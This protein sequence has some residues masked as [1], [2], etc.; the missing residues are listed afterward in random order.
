VIALAQSPRCGCGG[1]LILSAEHPRDAE[2][3]H[4]LVCLTCEACLDGT[5]EQVDRA[6]TCAMVRIRAMDRAERWA[7]RWSRVLAAEGQTGIRYAVRM[8][9]PRQVKFRL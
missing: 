1:A 8:R 3:L 7:L 4:A 2:L 9:R 5:Q 6:V